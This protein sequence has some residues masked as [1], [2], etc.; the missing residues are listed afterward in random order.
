[1]AFRRERRFGRVKQRRVV[2]LQRFVSTLARRHAGPDSHARPE[3][4]AW[5]GGKPDAH[6][7]ANPHSDAHDY[8]NP[9]GKRNP[10]TDCGSNGNPHAGA[11]RHPDSNPRSNGDAYPDAR[12]FTRTGSFSGLLRERVRFGRAQRGERGERV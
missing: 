9:D 12:P 4:R 8:A 10:G 7:N 1:L 2:G 3:R 5:R 6:S 11:H